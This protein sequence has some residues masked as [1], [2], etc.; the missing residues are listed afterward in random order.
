MVGRSIILDTCIATRLIPHFFFQLLA[1][2]EY[3]NPVVLAF[4]ECI[5]YSSQSLV[6]R[7]MPDVKVSSSKT[8]N[9]FCRSHQKRWLKSSSHSGA[10]NSKK[11]LEESVI[12][13]DIATF[14]A[15]T[16]SSKV[17]NDSDGTIAVNVATTSDETEKLLN[18]SLLAS[19]RARS[20]WFLAYT[21]IHNPVVSF[22][23]V[24]FN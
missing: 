20:R 18:S 13:A 21:L 4:I 7:N 6:G 16:E 5:L 1:D 17:M 14:A 15:A 24:V 3:N 2:H 22:C 8:K 23:L 19:K 9:R 10:S 12:D 11:D